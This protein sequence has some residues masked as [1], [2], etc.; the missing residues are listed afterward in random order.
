MATEWPAKLKI[1]PIRP[2]IESLPTPTCLTVGGGES[3]S[4]ASAWSRYKAEPYTSPHALSVNRNHVLYI[5]V[6]QLLAA[7]CTH[8]RCSVSV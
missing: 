8:S 3:G 2:L 6:A 7:R 5:L 1:F 4:Q